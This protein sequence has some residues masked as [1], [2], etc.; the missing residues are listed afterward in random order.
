MAQGNVYKQLLLKETFK[1][2]LKYKKTR[3]NRILVRQIYLIL[4]LFINYFIQ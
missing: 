2:K 1:F 4:P 3:N